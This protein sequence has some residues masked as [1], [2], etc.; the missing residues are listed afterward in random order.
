MLYAPADSGLDSA[1]LVERLDGDFRQQ[2][3]VPGSST[4]EGEASEWGY[5]THVWFVQWETAQ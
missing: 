4:Q 3:A 5:P 2:F 1:T